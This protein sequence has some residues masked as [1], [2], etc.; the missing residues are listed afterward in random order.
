MT[1]HDRATERAKRRQET[2]SER[3]RSRS[4]QRLIDG[5]VRVLSRELAQAAGVAVAQAAADQLATVGPEPTGPEPT[6]DVFVVFAEEDP[7]QADEAR[8]D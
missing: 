6:G 1:T 5:V 7:P 8:E 2:R 4:N 3:I